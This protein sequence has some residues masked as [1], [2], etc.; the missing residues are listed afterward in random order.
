MS[1]GCLVQSRLC[2]LSDVD[3][4]MSWSRSGFAI[5]IPTFVG[6]L[7]GAFV[8]SLVGLFEGFADGC[9]VGLLVGLAEGL[10]VG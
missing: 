2:E 4:N 9:A 3:M 5:L 1:R 7:L 6:F 8:G 10:F